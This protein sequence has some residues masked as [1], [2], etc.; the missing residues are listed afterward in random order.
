MNYTV[1]INCS[2]LRDF[3][4][5]Y[6][7]QLGWMQNLFPSLEASAYSNLNIRIIHILAAS[8]KYPDHHSQADCITEHII[9]PSTHFVT[10]R[11]P[12]KKICLPRV[13]IPLTVVKSNFYCPHKTHVTRPWQIG[14]AL[15]NFIFI[16]HYWKTQGVEKITP[17]MRRGRN[18]VVSEF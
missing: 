18:L 4:E 15:P 9:H 11:G 2:S 16:I 17:E 12:N 1:L 5:G 10:S 7:V 8:E 3:L 14:S 13:V 6:S